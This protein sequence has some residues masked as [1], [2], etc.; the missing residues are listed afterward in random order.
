MANQNENVGFYNFR[1]IRHI[2][3]IFKD[4]E[5]RS[6]EQVAFSL[7]V[8]FNRLRR[9]YNVA[10]FPTKE[11]F[12]SFRSYGVLKQ[13]VLESAVGLFDRAGFAPF[14]FENIGENANL[15]QGVTQSLFHYAFLETPQRKRARFLLFWEQEFQEDVVRPMFTNL[16]NN[17]DFI[18]AREVRNAYRAPLDERISYLDGKLKIS[19]VDD[20][21]ARLKKQVVAS[22]LGTFLKN[23][24]TRGLDWRNL[25]G[26]KFKSA[27]NKILA[28]DWRK[29]LTERHR[30]RR[31]MLEG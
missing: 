12:D 10:Y 20:E 22:T 31:D 28:E 24:G 3:G 11:L 30:K 27:F 2:A 14:L 6:V 29:R 25:K 23:I 1:D 7:E 19:V 8:A 15:A 17:F 18:N 4:N 16:L 26:E 5:Y 9:N 13:S 21:L